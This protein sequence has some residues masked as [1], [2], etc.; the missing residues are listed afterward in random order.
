MRYPTLR[1]IS[2]FI[3]IIFINIIYFDILR[4]ISYDI[5][6]NINAA[7]VLSISK[8]FNGLFVIV[9]SSKCYK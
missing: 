8:F 7:F 5:E 9:E 4:I 2:N 6:I 1:E 3:N